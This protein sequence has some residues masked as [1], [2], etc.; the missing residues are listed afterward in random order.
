[1][2]EV[3]QLEGIVHPLSAHKWQSNAFFI[4]TFFFRAAAAA[5]QVLFIKPSLKK[6]TKTHTRTVHDM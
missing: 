1:M 2:C 6:A 4:V 5:D 3:E